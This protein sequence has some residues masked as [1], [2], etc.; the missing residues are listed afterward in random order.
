MRDIGSVNRHMDGTWTQ[1]GQQLP[2]KVTR[3]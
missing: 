2:F 1:G 3:E